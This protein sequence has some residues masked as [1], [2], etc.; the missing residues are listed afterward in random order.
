MNQLCIWFASIL[1]DQLCIWFTSIL[2]EHVM[3]LVY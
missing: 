3:Y 1:Y 2:Y